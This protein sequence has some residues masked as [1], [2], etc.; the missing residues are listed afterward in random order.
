MT[1]TEA[2]EIL[3]RRVDIDKECLFDEDNMSDFDIFIRE[4]DDAIELAIEALQAQIN[5]E[6]N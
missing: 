3:K 5:L 1:K 4:Q 6:E 2:V